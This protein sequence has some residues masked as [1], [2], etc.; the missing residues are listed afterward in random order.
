MTVEIDFT[1]S[2]TITGTITLHRRKAVFS[3]SI[4]NA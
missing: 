4:R 2:F 3:W 1:L